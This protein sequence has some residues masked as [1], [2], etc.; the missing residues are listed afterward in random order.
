MQ[1]ISGAKTR[2]WAQEDGV[3]TFSLPEYSAR[4]EMPASQWSY[5]CTKDSQLPNES[6]KTAHEC[7]REEMRFEKKKKEKRE[8][9]K[10]WRGWS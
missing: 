1:C 4:S 9:R 5:D 6:I 3:S 2:R 7:L 10:K 8:K